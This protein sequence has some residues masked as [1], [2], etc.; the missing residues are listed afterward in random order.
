MMFALLIINI[1]CIRFPFLVQIVQSPFVL[2]PR[3]PASPLAED[4]NARTDQTQEPV[5]VPNKSQSSNRH[6][7]KSKKHSKHDNLDN[8]NVDTEL[9]PKP[10]RHKKSNVD[11]AVPVPLHSGAESQAPGELSSGNKQPEAVDA[12]VE[13]GEPVKK[14]KKRTKDHQSKSERSRSKKAATAGTSALVTPGAL[15]DETGVAETSSK[16]KSSNRSNER[17][18]NVRDSDDLAPNPCVDQKIHV[19]A[20]PPVDPEAPVRHRAPADTSDVSLH[21]DSPEHGR[22]QYDSPRRSSHS[23]RFSSARSS[24]Y[25]RSPSRRIS[26]RRSD[27]RSYRERYRD[28]GPRYR[29]QERSRSPDPRHFQPRR[30]YVAYRP[31]SVGRESSYEDYSH[32]S[33][34]P[35]FR[36]SRSHSRSHGLSRHATENSSR[37]YDVLQPSGRSRDL[38]PR[39]TYSRRHYRDEPDRASRDS[40]PRRPIRRGK[41]MEDHRPRHELSAGDN[42]HSRPYRSRERVHDDSFPSPEHVVVS[43]THEPRR[44]L[45]SEQSRSREFVR[46]TDT[47]RRTTRVDKPRLSPSKSSAKQPTHSEHRSYE[48]KDLDRKQ[49]SLI[50]G[51]FLA[52]FTPVV[53]ES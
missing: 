10:K 32:E 31:P 20:L 22:R 52:F 28:R 48:E 3:P 2:M 34:V 45:S 47:E 33:R 40:P 39:R 37:D 5:D 50:F 12:P 53:G 46:S 25:S 27:V 51:S 24:S 15:V 43:D 13:E 26:D 11:K 30:T 9:V 36:R 41:H 17:S 6:L 42:R 44:D 35:R 29:A 49:V 14:R 38:S 23:S 19:S 16:T 4:H 1:L 7:K 18:K 8:Q 21:Q